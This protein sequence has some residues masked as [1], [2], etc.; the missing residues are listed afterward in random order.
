MGA[1]SPAPVSQSLDRVAGLQRWKLDAGYRGDVA[2]DRA[3]HV[4]PADCAHADRGQ[5]AGSLPGTSRRRHRGHVRPPPPVDFLAG[6]DAG[7]GGAVKRADHARS[8]LA[9]RAP[10][11]HVPVEYRQRDEQSGMAGDCSRTGAAR[12]VAG[13]DRAEQRGFQSGARRGPCPGRPGGG[14]LRFGPGG[15]G[16]GVS[17]KL[18]VLPGGD[19]CP[20]RVEA[21]AAV[22]KRAASRAHLRVHAERRALRAP[23][24]GVAHHPAARVSVYGFRQRG[25]GAARRGGAA[26]SARRRD[27]VW[28]TQRLP[29]PGRR[30]GS[31][32]AAA[33]AAD[34]ACR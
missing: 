18:R 7:H 6:L 14:R 28:R 25:V 15:R 27:G 10:G 32:F 19:L 33:L 2:D 31:S 17:S 12:G 29:G 34:G 5:P 22:Q 30:D 1:A 24:S 3:D 8:D 4:A 16:G 23:L 20:L 9:G 21:D 13:R 26:G 11:A